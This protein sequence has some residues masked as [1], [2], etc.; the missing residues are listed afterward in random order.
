MKPT[1]VIQQALDYIESHLAEDIGL[2]KLARQA[3]MSKYAFHRLFH[4]A[5]GEPVYQYIRR[6]R[7]EHAADRLIR[8]DQPIMEI[9]LNCR[10]SSQEAFSRAF[11]RIYALPP[12][13]YRRLFADK[14]RNI[15]RL[16]AYT[17]RSMQMAA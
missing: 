9:A 17:H 13:Q 14:N 16:S 6:C 1:I 8:T 7:M 2:E 11:Q 10:Y 4:Q 15:A 5:V 12:G 3:C